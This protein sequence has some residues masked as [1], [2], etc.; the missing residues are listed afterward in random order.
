LFL[1]SALS[2]RLWFL[3][4][5]FSAFHMQ[6]KLF[7]FAVRLGA[8]KYY[9]LANVPKNLSVYLMICIICILIARHFICISP[10]NWI[11]LE[12]ASLIQC[13]IIN[14]L[15]SFSGHFFFTRAEK[16]RH[17]TKRGHYLP[18]VPLPRPLCNALVW[19]YIVIHL[20][21]TSSQV[22]ITLHKID[23]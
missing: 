7:S 22:D 6:I 21:S 18:T 19:A 3:Y 2:L 1:Y 11:P 23:P 12:C 5:W 17:K 10:F 15:F 8:E 13:V 20:F 14:F 9:W 4:F 16:L